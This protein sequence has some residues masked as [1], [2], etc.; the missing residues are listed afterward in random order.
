MASSRD[1][2]AASSGDATGFTLPEGWK[3]VIKTVPIFEARCSKGTECG[4]KNRL[5][6]KKTTREEA[7]SQLAYHY[8]DV[9]KHGMTWEDA[10]LLH[11]DMVSPSIQC[12]CF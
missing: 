6:Y 10:L 2:G 7:V 4:K 11:W 9:A 1:S 12:H 3:K 5:L 8:F